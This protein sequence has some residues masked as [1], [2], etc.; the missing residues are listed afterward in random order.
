MRL[1][2]TAD[3]S[4]TAYDPRYQDHYHS[5]AGA[6]MQARELYLYGSGV[7]ADGKPRVIELGFGLGVNFFTT[8]TDVCSRDGFLEY[9]AIEKQ[10]VA[11]ELLE[12]ALVE[13]R[14]TV[15]EQVLS[16][17]GGSFTIGGDCFE[18]RLLVTDAADW[19]PLTDW[20]S[21]VYYDPFN[22]KT[23]PDA[24]EPRVIRRFFRATAPGG[25]L[26]TYSVASRVRKALVEVGYRVGKIAARGEKRNWTRAV[27]PGYGEA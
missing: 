10:P 20:A 5:L 12:A 11:A 19:R 23:N 24:W 1:V 21:A 15:L 22:P 4:L 16:A 14:G 26:V 17:W 7:V 6:A 13:Y 9:L 25:V 2:E 8:L 18:L 27:K 3:G